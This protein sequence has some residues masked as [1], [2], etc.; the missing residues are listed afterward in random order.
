MFL[1]LSNIF[2]VSCEWPESLYWSISIISMSLT[3]EESDYDKIWL[4]GL[5]SY[6]FKY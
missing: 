4:A 6:I 3:E 2:E 1:M 5:Y